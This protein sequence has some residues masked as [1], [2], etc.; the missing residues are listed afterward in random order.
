MQVIM[1]C[2]QTND[3]IIQTTILGRKIHMISM[4]RFL[5]C[6]LTHSAND[7]VSAFANTRLQ[8]REDTKL[9]KSGF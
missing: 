7:A 8:M 3:D 5:S 6:I 9:M 4:T 1:D 2:W